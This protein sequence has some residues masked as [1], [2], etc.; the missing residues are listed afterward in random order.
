MTGT[1]STISLCSIRMRLRAALQ[2]S[3]NVLKEENE[4]LKENNEDLKENIDE[5]EEN[6]DSLENIQRFK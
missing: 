1:F 5:L 3:V 2:N 6:I 4:E